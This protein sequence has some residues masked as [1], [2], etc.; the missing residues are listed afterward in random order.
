MIEAKKIHVLVLNI[1]LFVVF[2]YV[3]FNYYKYLN[4]YLLLD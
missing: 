4:F 2:F 1:L 3:F